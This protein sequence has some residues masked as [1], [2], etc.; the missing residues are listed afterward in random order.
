MYTL[1][2]SAKMN[3]I[4]PQ[5]WM[6]DVL[7]HLPDLPVSRLPELLPWSWK[8]QQ[9]AVRRCLTVACVGCIPTNQGDKGLCL[10][11][12]AVLR[13][14]SKGVGATKIAHQLG[15][16]CATVNKILNSARPV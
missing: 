8:T 14:R 10:R 6:A 7:A 13:L 11:R 9:D 4:D 1:I 16:G 5:A 2:V 3:Y 12:E 15:I